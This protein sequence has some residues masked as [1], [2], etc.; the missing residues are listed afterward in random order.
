MFRKLIILPCLF[1]HGVLAAQVGQHFPEWQPGYLDIHHINTGRGESVFSILPDGTTMLVDAGD[2][3]RPKPRV[4]DPK[5]NAQ[6]TSG[7]WISRYILHMLAGQKQKKLDYILLSH[8][9]GDHMGKITPGMKVSAS[10]AYKLSGITEVGN[11]I[12]FDKIIDRGWTYPKPPKG[13][14][15]A[16]YMQFVKWQVANKKVKTEQFLP[17]H[18]DQITLV[19]EPGKYP[20]FVIQNIASNGVVWTGSGQNSR[21]FF[22][23]LDSLQESEYPDENM[24]SNAFR[25][26]YGKF[27]YFTGGDITSGVIPDSWR[28]IEGPIGQVTGQVEVCEVNHHAYY[29]A[30]STGFLQSVRPRAYVIQACV[31]SHPAVGSLARM[32]SEEIYPG[33]RDIF[34]TNLMEE[35]KIVVGGNI[36]KM[37]SQNGHVVVR[38]LPGGD[39]YYVFIL[40]DTA[41]NYEVKAVFGP[42]QSN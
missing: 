11:T 40:D 4:T 27:D 38:V 26:S 19:R 16:N 8:F 21:S 33:P 42:Y 22:P 41:E 14:L 20:G 29:D 5:P 13:E 17:G 24:C 30:M 34:S 10:G 36:D 18:R 15:F 32:L 35:T 2:I 12:P 37:K 25:M 3:P 39:S 6:R 7:E 9:H 28:N 31:P 1:F 23:P